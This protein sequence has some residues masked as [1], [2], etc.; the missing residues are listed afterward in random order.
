MI[1]RF[2]NE[3]AEQIDGQVSATKT[4]DILVASANRF[5]RLLE[6][7]QSCDLGLIA[8]AAVVAL[9]RVRFAATAEGRSLGAGPVRLDC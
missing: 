7:D 3:F 6:R 5:D 4:F 9:D 8:R 2:I 1:D